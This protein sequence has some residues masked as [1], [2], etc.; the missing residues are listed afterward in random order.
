MLT[1]CVISNFFYIEKKNFW[2]F[3][4]NTYTWEPRWLSGSA[5]DSNHKGLGFD[6][7]S[8]EK[9]GT[10]ETQIFHVFTFTGISVVR[11]P[12]ITVGPVVGVVASSNYL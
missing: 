1:P 12:L 9:A 8:R 10:T 11:N 5:L 4:S 7:R 3:D 2:N 6:S